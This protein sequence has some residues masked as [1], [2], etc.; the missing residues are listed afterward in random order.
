[1]GTTALMSMSGS[2]LFF[3]SMAD[4]TALNAPARE[5]ASIAR[6]VVGAAMMKGRYTGA[7]RSTCPKK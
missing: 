6:G 5:N 1:M 3:R 2:I 4:L 7:L